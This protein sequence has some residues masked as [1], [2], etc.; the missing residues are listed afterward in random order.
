MPA[1]GYVPAA[2]ANA[3]SNGLWSSPIET[4]LVGIHLNVFSDGQMMYYGAH[5]EN[6]TA[7]TKSFSIATLSP[8]QSFSVFPEAIDV[9][10]FCTGNINLPDGRVLLTGGTSSFPVDKDENDDSP[11]YTGA[12]LFATYSK[13]QTKLQKMPGNLAFS[14]WYPT[15][16]M[17]NDRRVVVIGGLDDKG[18]PVAFPEVVNTRTGETRVLDRA[19]LSAAGFSYPR[20]VKVADNKLVVLSRNEGA[21]YLL[22]TTGRG[23]VQT[24]NK[25]ADIPSGPMASIGANSYLVAGSRG[26]RLGD[27]STRIVEFSESRVKVANAANMVRA[28]TYHELTT[29]PDGSVL[30]TGG[31]DGKDQPSHFLDA[32]L[33]VK[34]KG[35]KTMSSASL[36]RGYHTT[37]ALLPDATV[38]TMGSTRPTQTQAEIFYPPYLFNS[39][40]IPKTRPTIE[41]WGRIGTDDRAAISLVLKDNVSVKSVALIRTGAVTH[42]TSMGQ[43]FF[44]ANFAQNGKNI[45]VNVSQNTSI[46]PA[47]VYWVF[48][49][50]QSGTPSIATAV[51]V[52]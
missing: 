8:G 4:G 41:S 12:N 16:V 43:T 6:S 49:I 24:L 20:S 25:E 23:T 30:A 31:T 37:A 15:N 21:P 33:W 10:S 50:D 3:A 48:V 13:G 52:G 44:A 42:Q 9:G 2:T 26:N 18:K 45:T 28:R 38:I 46:L 36:R 40:G 17:L 7:N 14:R 47:G 39:Q 29:L 11:R 22:T 35:W 1:L 32:E 19:D 51:R 5:V 34:S 27:K